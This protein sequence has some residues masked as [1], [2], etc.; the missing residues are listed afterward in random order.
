MTGVYVSSE[1]KL[2]EM[3]KQLSLL[4][5]TFGKNPRKRTTGSSIY[6]DD[7]SETIPPS[8]VRSMKGLECDTVQ[9]AEPQD[10]LHSPISLSVMA[11]CQVPQTSHSTSVS[12]VPASSPTCDIALTPQSS[13]CQPT[14]IVFP[15]TYF[16]GKARSFNPAWYK[17]W[18]WLEY[19]VSKDAAFCYPC[20]MFSTSVSASTSRP[21]K[22]FS[23]TGFRDWKHATGAKGILTSCLSHKEAVVAWEQF[24]STQQRGS[25]AELLGNVRAEQ[26]QRKKH[27]IKTIAEVLLLCSK[28]EIEIRGHRES[29]DS[30]NKGN[31]G[32]ILDLVAKHDSVVEQR[33]L[34]GPRNAIYTSQNTILNIMAK[35]VRS[36]ICSSVKQA[37]FYSVLADE[38]KDL[39]KI[40]QL[41][42]VV[43]YV[44]VGSEKAIIKEHFLTYV[45][46]SSLNAESLSQYILDTLKTYNLDVNMMISQG[47]DGASV[48][49]GEC[50]GVQQRI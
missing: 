13:P 28:Q 8:P 10:T 26:I 45:E 47:H 3:S 6:S 20:R 24:Q 49:S 37:G 46:T 41:A 36:K 15:S 32:E 21:E 5:F 9:S 4:E 17:Q 33:L 23:K 48:M 34:H 12:S 25:V 18:P 19:S 14:R 30:T 7:D 29:I 39:S 1:H 43:R 38:T 16:S 50:S 35:I 22:T 2:I 31:F 44:D 42:I 40:E 27:Y 11:V